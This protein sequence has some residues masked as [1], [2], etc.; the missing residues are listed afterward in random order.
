MSIRKRRV[1]NRLRMVRAE[2]RMTQFVLAQK[3]RIHT[4]RISHIENALVEPTSDEKA[5]LARALKTDVEIVFPA[6]VAAAPD[7][8]AV[9]S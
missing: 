6:P 4:S 8:E 2:R 7:A 1:A 5:R 9:A 3:S